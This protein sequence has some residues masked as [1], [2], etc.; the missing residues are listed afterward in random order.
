M[1]CLAD[2]GPIFGW[3]G[4]GSSVS[5]SRG[6]LMC[7]LDVLAIEPAGPF[8]SEAPEPPMQFCYLRRATL[9]WV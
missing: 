7:G 1:R 6:S 3:R 2:F 5:G 4:D 8:V 9:K